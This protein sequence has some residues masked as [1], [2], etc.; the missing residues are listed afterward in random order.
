[1]QFR[2]IGSPMTARL[3]AADSGHRYRLGP[4]GP[5]DPEISGTGA[6]LLAWLL[7]RGDGSG[8]VQPGPGPLPSV[9]S[10]YM[11]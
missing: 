11:T 8:L 5:D 2:Q 10:V 9:P 7:G 4:A 3:H 1:L 6:D